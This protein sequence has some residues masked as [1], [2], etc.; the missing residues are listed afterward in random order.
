MIYYYDGD[1]YQWV[2]TSSGIVGPQGAQGTIGSQGTSGTQGA[3]GF[4][5]A[6]GSQGLQGI[7]GLTGSQGTQGVQGSQGL[8]GI[9]GIS[10]YVGS[11]GAQGT[12]GIQ[13]TQGAQ[14]ITGSQGTQGAQ[15][16]QGIQGIQ[17]ITGS[18]GT[19]GAQGIQGTQGIQGIQGITGSQGTQGTQGIQGITGEQGIQ[20]TQG[21]QGITGAQGTAGTFG[22]AAFDY[23]F[24]T[25]T[26]NSDPGTGKLRLNA[27]DLSTASAL[28]INE[29]DDLSVSI[30]NF[31]QTIDDSTSSI[32]G[33][34]TITQKNDTNN[35]AMFSITG[36]HSHGSNYFNVPVSY[37]SGATSFTNN[38]DIIITFARTG[39][40][41][42]TGSQGT[43]GIQG[44]TGEQG[45]QGT[46]GTQGIQ[47]IQGITGSQG[48]QGAQ[49]IQGS[50]GI[51]G[52]QGITGAQG[53]SGS[54]GIS[55]TQG[56]QGIQGIQ[57]AQGTQGIQGIQG[58]QG[59][60]GAQGTVGAQGITGA[61]GVTGLQGT[62][63]IQGVQGIQGITGVNANVLTSDTAPTSP[64]AGDLWWDS[65]VGMMRIYYYDGTSSQWVD[66]D[67]GSVQGIQGA[68]GTQGIQGIQG[69]Q[70]IQGVQGIQGTLGAQGTQGTQ[71][72][73]GISGASILGT[74][75]TWTGTNAFTTLSA[76]GAITL[77]GTSSI[78]NFTDTGSG[79]S[80]NWRIATSE[81][82]EGDFLI[83][84][85]SAANLTPSISALGFDRNGA[86]TF[87]SNVAV[88]GALTTTGN[89]GIG[90][91]PSAWAS[92]YKVL[93]IGQS[94]ALATD[95]GSTSVVRLYA[96]TYY[97]GT[98]LRY[99]N[100]NFASQYLQYN[101]EHSWFIAP[102]GTAG[103]VYSHVRVMTLNTSG[104]LG[105]G[106]TSPAY[107][108]DVQTSSEYQISWT[109]TSSSKTWAFGS[110]SLGTY[111][112]NRTDSVLPM[113]ITNAGN[114]GI[115]T[116]SPSYRLD[117]RALSTATA[118]SF[119]STNTTAYSATSYNGGAARIFLSTSNATNAVNGMV[120][121]TG[122]NNETF[123][124]AVQ[125]SSGTGA[126][127]FQGYDGSYYKE[128]MRIEG[129]GNVGIGTTSPSRKLTV[130]ASGDTRVL[131]K[132][133]TQISTNAWSLA[134]SHGSGSAGNFAIGQEGV[135][136]RVSVDTSG[137][138][139]IGT[140]S[141]AKTLDVNGTVQFRDA[142]GAGQ[143]FWVA[144][145]GVGSTNSGA[146]GLGYNAV[147]YT[148]ASASSNIYWDPNTGWFTLS[149]SSRKYKRNIV[150]VTD[151][152]LDKALLLKPSYYQRN[153]YE[154][155]EYG[156][157][158]EEVN[159]I[160]LDEFVTR[161]EGEISGL[162]YEKM[163]TLA[164][165]LAQRQAKENANLVA[166]LQSVRQRLAALES[167]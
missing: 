120:F 45:I 135:G 40:V 158:A 72:I 34:F 41:G 164:I 142:A 19:Q 16:E 91:T 155:Y 154:Y 88:T 73:Q 75:N 160:G 147:N 59:A 89:V 121:T 25:S 138:V 28:Y 81:A 118:A 111:F 127:V 69:T 63:G 48:T 32:K 51:Q 159:E 87:A 162:N 1:S 125:E 54:Q 167:K 150:A 3:S 163:V 33:H 151:E 14:G 36:A 18:Q 46:Q 37:L 44:I 64:N 100:T 68:Q 27:S 82:A 61:Q 66:V 106:T 49:G 53:I 31:L 7:Q 90:V 97:D 157:I 11:D 132:D 137:N 23:T 119:S 153:E 134:V 86:A 10:G 13:G 42:A 156:F 20:G 71:G 141:P 78:L 166:E 110:D 77:T 47:G 161:V 124:G 30:Y 80:R 95:T 35:F 60:V 115:G 102:S 139:G 109:R 93:Q 21:T 83:Q 165:G 107:R 143:A 112:A 92:T 149:T 144:N 2:T 136:I 70:G 105:I 126:F 55:G 5:G 50:Q 29:N 108:L 98:N 62:Q 128:R 103:D 129:S 146:F 140:S 39:D 79:T 22:G 43:Q 57:G 94:G 15:G 130:E 116:S 38:L 104:N 131:I 58:I 113:Y 8:Q 145:K 117:V 96:N 152:Q 123:F 6:Q 26:T 17:G 12:Q 52:I 24:D 65:S 133:S 76:T 56:A 4:N 122:A 114:V 85:S 9:Q 101:G 74:N 67:P 99:L 84:V 148:P